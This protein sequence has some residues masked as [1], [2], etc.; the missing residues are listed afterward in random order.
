MH[1]RQVY[2]LLDILGD[3]GGV[4]EV[5]MVVMGALLMPIAEH[6]FTLQA[7]KRI[8]MAKTTDPKLFLNKKYGNCNQDVNEKLIK[9]TEPKTIKQY[10]RIT[11]GP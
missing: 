2:G 4:L 11:T 10:T 7:A 8:F 1:L 5:I 6:H 3:L 9:Y